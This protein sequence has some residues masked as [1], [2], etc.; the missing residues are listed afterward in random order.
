VIY[1]D[2]A[3]VVKLVRVEQHTADLV[4]WLNARPD[5]PLAASVVASPGA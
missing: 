2:S 4:T 1:L 5:A 3:A